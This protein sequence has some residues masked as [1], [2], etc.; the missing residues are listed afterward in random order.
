MKYK[1]KRNAKTHK[2]LVEED[3]RYLWGSEKDAVRLPLKEAKEVQAVI[4]FE[5]EL[6]NSECN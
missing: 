1:I 6:H 3:G 2:F 5:T 4:A